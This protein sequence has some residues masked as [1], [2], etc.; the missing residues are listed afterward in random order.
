MVL[1]LW[2][3]QTVPLDVTRSP[4]ASNWEPEPWQGQGDPQNPT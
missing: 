2:R 1:V 3:Q 4:W